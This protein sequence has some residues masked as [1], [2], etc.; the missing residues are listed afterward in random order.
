MAERFGSAPWPLKFVA[1]NPDLWAV[2]VALLSSVTLLASLALLKRKRWGRRLF[3]AM[4]AVLMAWALVTMPSLLVMGPQD[5][6]I[7]TRVPRGLH[8]AFLVVRAITVGAALLLIALCV[9]IV[10]RL[11]SPPIRAEFKGTASGSKR[12]SG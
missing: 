11:R 1:T 4:L 2:L 9:A 6:W 3:I 7:G 10:R 5:F 8:F 12:T